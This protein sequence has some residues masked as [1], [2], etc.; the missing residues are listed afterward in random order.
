MRM[1]AA[2]TLPKPDGKQ[3]FIGDF[4]NG[5]YVLADAGL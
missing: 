4:R 5:V 1:T 3:S 2:V